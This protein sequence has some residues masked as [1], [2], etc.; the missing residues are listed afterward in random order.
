MRIGGEEHLG[1]SGETLRVTAAPGAAMDEDE[2]RCR[3]ASSSVNI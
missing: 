1:R 2:D 3:G